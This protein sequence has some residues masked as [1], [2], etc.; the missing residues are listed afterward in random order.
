M[1][2]NAGL[3]VNPERC[4]RTNRH[5]LQPDNRGDRRAY[6]LYPNDSRQYAARRAQL[7]RDNR[8]HLRHTDGGGYL[9]LHAVGCRWGTPQATT[10]QSYTIQI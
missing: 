3:A 9:E 2:V 6:T 8:N 5:P 1:T 7:Q 4:P 10:T